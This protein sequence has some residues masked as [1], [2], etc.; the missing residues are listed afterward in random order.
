MTT[1]P[2]VARL[3]EQIAM[4]DAPG[5]PKKGPVQSVNMLI[6]SVGRDAIVLVDAPPNALELVLGRRR[7]PDPGQR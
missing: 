4:E 6:G 7:P 5:L 1:K 3:L 2:D